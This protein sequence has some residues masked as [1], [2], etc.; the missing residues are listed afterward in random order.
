VSV[1]RF[2][3][4]EKAAHSIAIMCRVREVSRS[5]Y[6]AWTRRPL[7]PR[8]VEDARLT[9]RI[10]ELHAKRRGVYSSPRIWSDL[11]LDD[12]ERIGRKRVERLM[13]QAGLSGLITKSSFHNEEFLSRR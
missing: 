2:F 6:H 4:A 1:Y 8:A 10:R 9:E 12:G 5:G 7:A 13:R 11:V 3:A